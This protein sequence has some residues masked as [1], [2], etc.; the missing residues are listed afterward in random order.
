MNTSTTAG[1]ST[2][3]SLHEILTAV[4]MARCGECWK[5]PDTPCAHSPA[6]SDGFHVARL[7]RAF[8]RGLIS[9]PDLVAVL[10]TVVVFTMATVVYDGKQPDEAADDAT[11][12]RCGAVSWGMTPDGLPQCTRCLWP[13]GAS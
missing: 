12:P 5:E 2:A 13:G 3:R 7:A 11:C 1:P 6:G 10:Q 4:R 9:G 8:R